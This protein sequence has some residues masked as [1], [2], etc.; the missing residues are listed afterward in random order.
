[1]PIQ[2]EDSIAGLI[3]QAEPSEERI[4]IV[5]GA[6]TWWQ[7]FQLFDVASSQNYVLGFEGSD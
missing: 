6:A 2:R 3:P 1:M 5:T 7:L 4:R